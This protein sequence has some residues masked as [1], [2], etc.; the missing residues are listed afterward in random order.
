MEENVGKILYESIVEHKWIDITYKHDNC[1]TYFWIAIIDIVN[2]SKKILKCKMVNYR[3]GYKNAEETTIVADRIISARLINGS[4]FKCSDELIDAISS[5]PD[6][7]SWLEPQHFNDN[8]LRYVCDCYKLDNDPC[9]LE[10]ESHNISGLA[11]DDFHN[12][13]AVLTQEQLDEFVELIL[14]VNKEDAKDKLQQSEIC[15][16]SLAISVKD[17]KYV[18]AY[19]KI[20]IDFDKK[21]ARL[22]EKSTINKS[23]LIDGKKYNLYNYIQCDSS[24]FVDNFD[25]NSKMYKELIQSNLSFSEKID[26]R[27]E[28]FIQRRDFVCDIDQVANE[29]VKME[30]D[31]QLTKP[32]MAYFGKNLSKRKAKNKEPFIVIRDKNANPDQIRVVY[33]TMTNYITYVEG[34]PGTGKTKTIVNVI[35]SAMANN[36]S[37]LIC[38]NNNK[39]IKDIYDSIKFIYK[40]GEEVLFPMIRIGNNDVNA[41][42]IETISKLYKQ[43][44]VIK[45]KRLNEALTENSKEKG[46]AIF[47]D[48]KKTLDDYEQQ[49]ELLQKEKC[50]KKIEK[51]LDNKQSKSFLLEELENV[52]NELKQYETIT[53]SNIRK[54]VIPADENEDYKNY[55]Y[56]KSLCYIK[57]LADKTNKDLIDIIL[58]Q[59]K[60][61]ALRLFNKYLSDDENL[62]KFIS[63][64]PFVITTNLSANKLGTPRPH[65]ELCIMDES[66]QC[67]IATSLL[68]IVRA[69]S[70]LLV[71][72]INQLKPVIVLEENLNK[73]LMKKYEIPNNYNYI[74]NSILSLM[75][76]NDNTSKYIRLRYHYR[77][78]KKIINFSNK[79]FYDGTL[80]LENEKEA[81]FKFIN[82]ENNKK[83][84]IGNAYEAEAEAIVDIIENNKYDDVS[85]ITAFRNQ[86]TLIN[87]KLNERGIEN[88]NA[89]TIHTIQGAEKNTIIF[90][91]A[92]SQKTGERTF[93]WIKNNQQL[94]NVGIS[95]SKR[96]FIMCGDYE[97]I[98]ALDKGENSI[99]LQLANYVRTNGDI[100][101]VE[102]I[103]NLK[104]NF[105]ND[106]KTESEMYETLLPFFKLK[107]K[108]SI[109]RNQKVCEV[110][111]ISPKDY[112]DYYH[113][114]EFD[115]V[116]F[117]KNIW[118]NK[119][120]LLIIEL[121]G[122]EHISCS[123]A[124]QNDRKKEIICNQVKLKVLRVP[125]SASKDYDYL[126]EVLSKLLN[127]D[128]PLTI[129]DEAEE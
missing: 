34:P 100:T 1:N 51:S 33:N 7:Y 21:E 27:E 39:P 32:L 104:S 8:I 90:S 78:P 12:Y 118:G 69:K 57:K 64:F 68:P 63:I 75:K 4:Y 114:S 6:R 15:L 43:A 88:V 9:I 107:S 86:A 66:G 13:V 102:L 48:L 28:V 61:E 80:I 99:I 77:C 38:S 73:K 113:R 47:K 30:N 129:F 103:P 112:K 16:S 44:V 52:H 62:N 72:D 35:L 115:F 91:T 74:D 70:L 85:I 95:R 105:S 22:D 55:L 58:S 101:T 124:V 45:D 42:T 53:D 94:I 92:L 125:N 59:D 127:L 40:N 31:N 82:V 41:E 20:S 123:K 83:S 109:E 117:K 60:E 49:Q 23:F 119:Q 54:L 108:I 56:Y 71:G 50:L 98:K 3:K 26:T 111:K 46:L 36:Q 18:I 89:G 79:L 37:C 128:K 87:K 10:T 14:K 110:L 24:E 11:Y 116:I 76:N 81:N 97:V 5:F 122:G 17:K 126:I 93:N 84:E 121:D 29:I 120:P 67:N 2:Y 96:D 19:R 65:F 25:V 106:S